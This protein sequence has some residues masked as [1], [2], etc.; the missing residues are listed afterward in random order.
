MIEAQFASE[1]CLSAYKSRYACA[2]CYLSIFSCQLDFRFLS[3]PQIFYVHLL[4]D[5]SAVTVVTVAT[6]SPKPSICASIVDE[7]EW[8]KDFVA[9][10][11]VEMR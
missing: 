11:V 9:G 1:L 6:G 2:R 10:C 7:H 3:Q 5:Y 8:C 4:I